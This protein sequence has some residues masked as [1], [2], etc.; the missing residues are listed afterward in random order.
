[1][2]QG[3]GLNIFISG[4]ETSS[5]GKVNF[6]FLSGWSQICYPKSCNVIYHKPDD[7]YYDPITLVFQNLN[8][9][10]F[11]TIKIFKFTVTLLSTYTMPITTLSWVSTIAGMKYLGPLDLQ[12][13]VPAFH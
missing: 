5:A 4:F 2:F 11:P 7:Q 13:Q 12:C 3:K 6:V 8:S 10:N 9:N 1:M